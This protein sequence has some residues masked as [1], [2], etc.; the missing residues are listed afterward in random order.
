MEMTESATVTSKGSVN[1]P[2]KIRRKYGIKSGYG[3]S[4]V[5]A[6]GGILMVPIPP[7]MDLFGSAKRYRQGLVDIVRNLERDRRKDAEVENS[8]DLRD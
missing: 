5:E 7:L 2:A 1:I 3:V 6:K 8:E 4:F